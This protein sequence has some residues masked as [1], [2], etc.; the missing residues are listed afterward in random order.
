[1]LNINKLNTFIAVAEVGS[2]SKAASILY[3]TQPAISQAVKELESELGYPLLER[4]NKKVYL[5]KEG[6]ALYQHCAPLLQSIIDKSKELKVDLA[7]L[8]GKIR[9]GV[10]NDFSSHL[11]HDVATKFQTTFPQVSLNF[12]ALGLYEGEDA[13]LKGELDF[14]FILDYKQ[15]DRFETHPYASF[16]RTPMAARSFLEGKPEIK[17]IQ[18]LLAYPIIGLGEQSFGLRFWLNKNGLKGHEPEL[19]QALSSLSVSI[20]HDYHALVKAGMGVGFC[21]QE[22]VEQE[23]KSGELIPLLPQYSP[24]TNTLDICRRKTHSQSLLMNTFWEFM[25]NNTLS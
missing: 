9:I 22:L 24:L 5:T 21:Y 18:D 3:K 15:K 20:M 10:V 17:Q 19:E 1:M 12:Q 6:Q 7:Q 14:A 2:I 11:C 16:H 23:L 4:R 13:L 25:K 8:S